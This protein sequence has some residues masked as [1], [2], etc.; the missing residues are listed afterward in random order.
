MRLDETTK[1]WSGMEPLWRYKGLRTRAYEELVRARI[2]RGPEIVD[3]NSLTTLP[4]HPPGH[5][6][7]PEHGPSLNKK[8]YAKIETWRETGRIEDKHPDLSWMGPR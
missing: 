5:P 3:A 6:G 4:Y 8:I 1:R 7:E 2:G